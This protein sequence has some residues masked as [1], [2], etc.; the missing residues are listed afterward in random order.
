M[1]ANTEVLVGSKQ[2]PTPEP[3]VAGRLVSLDVIRGL[4]VASMI[5]VVTPGSWNYR[6][7]QLLHADWYGW[8]LADMVFPM[9]LFAVGMAVVF[10]YGSHFMRGDT[11]SGLARKILRRNLVILVLGLVLNLFPTF[12]IPHLRIPGILQQIATC[13]ALAAFLC[14]AF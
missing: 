10:S 3:R 5:L 14:L 2:P 7:P 13:Y 11:K 4:A 12:D 1:A 8:T 9:F 6:Y